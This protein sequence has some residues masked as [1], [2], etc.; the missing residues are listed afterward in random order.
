MTARAC[1]SSTGP[2]ANA[3]IAIKSSRPT[4]QDRIR[5]PDLPR[6]VQKFGV[7]TAQP[8]QEIDAVTVVV[9]DFKQSRDRIIGIADPEIGLVTRLGEGL[10]QGLRLANLQCHDERRHRDWSVRLRALP[11]PLHR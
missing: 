11:P 4:L 8:D 6:A 5:E 1:A 7:H 10:P 3:F 9:P 2:P